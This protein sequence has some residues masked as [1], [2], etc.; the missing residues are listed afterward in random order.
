MKNPVHIQVVLT[1]KPE[2][3]SKCPDTQSTLSYLVH[4][5]ATEAK[6]IIFSAWNLF[7]LL[8][9]NLWNYSFSYLNVPQID[10]NIQIASKCFTALCINSSSILYFINTFENN[11]I[12]NFD[13]FSFF[14]FVVTSKMPIRWLRPCLFSV[15]DNLS[16]F[17]GPVGLGWEWFS[18]HIGVKDF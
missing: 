6:Q 1:Y 2:Q 5:R 15:S 8:F 14:L 10:K 3:E 13:S 9:S 18:Q 11:Y 16:Y 4:F 12:L 17:L 7:D